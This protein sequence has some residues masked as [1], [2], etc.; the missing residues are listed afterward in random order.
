MACS[1][2]ALRTAT[3]L[4]GAPATSRALRAADW[5]DRQAVFAVFRQAGFRSPAADTANRWL[6]RRDAT[7]LQRLRQL[8]G[9]EG[10]ATLTQ[11]SPQ[12]PT[13]LFLLLQ[14]AS[15]SIQT[16]YLPRIEALYQAGQLSA[17]NYATYLD[18]TLL[19]QGKPQQYGTQS[20]RVVRSGGLT[21][22]SLLPTAD[23][24]TVDQRRRRMKLEPL[25]PQLQPGTLYFKPTRSH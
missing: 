24:E 10:W 15:D 20:T 22:D 1:R 8:E 14:H 9:R 7:R 11:S 12:T 18:R 4:S 13:A 21:L 23:F 16:G 3:P 2:P 25:R 6:L 5:Q 17:P 19:Y